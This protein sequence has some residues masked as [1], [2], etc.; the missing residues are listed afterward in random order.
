MQINIINDANKPLIY[1]IMQDIPKPVRKIGTSHISL[2]GVLPS[3][4]NNT[5]NT[6]ESSLE[7]DYLKILE[8]DNLVHEY[9][10]QPIEILY[11]DGEF[12]RRYTPDVLIYYREDLKSSSEYSPLLV[13][14]KYRNDIKENWAELK[15]KF[16]AAISYAKQKGWRFKVLTEREIRTTYLE[17]VKFLL[18]FKKKKIVDSNDS[19]LLLDWIKKLD[20][21]TPDEILAA[22]ARDRY[23][24]AELLYSLW[25]LVALEMIGCDLF[26]PLT[27]KSEIWAK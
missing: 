4:K 7:R 2:R 20:I 6:F 8:F 24:Q 10:E 9:V 3:E 23:K 17:N 16:K 11:K 12:E 22:A 25:I 5:I 14:V 15:P 19:I 13:E 27:M 21:T 26:I 18:P 1:H